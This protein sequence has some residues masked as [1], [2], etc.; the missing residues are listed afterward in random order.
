MKRIT[1]LA[2]AVALLATS[3]QKTDI[4]NVAEDAIDFG[5][6]VGKLTKASENNPKATLEAQDFRVWTVADFTVGTDT[7]YKIYRGMENLTVEHNETTNG[8]AIKGSTKYLWPAQGN[9]LYFYAISAD[10]TDW[11]DDISFKTN[12][13]PAK[14][15]D[16]IRTTHATGL[17]LEEFTVKSTAH[18]DVMVADVVKK[19]KVSGQDNTVKPNF[20][21]T[22]TKVEFNFKHGAQA[23]GDAA[24]SEAATVILKGIE[25]GGYTYKDQTVAPGLVNKG[26]LAVTYDFTVGDASAED[27]KYPFKWSPSTETSDVIPFNKTPETVILIA[28]PAGTKLEA[29][30]VESTDKVV[31]PTND[32]LCMVYTKSE[33]VDS[34]TVYKY[35]AGETSAWT[36]VEKLNYNSDKKI[37]ASENYEAFAGLVLTSTEENFVTWYMIPQGISGKKV[38]LNYVADGKHLSQEFALTGTS[39]DANN[40]TIQI[41]WDEEKCVKYNVTIAP[42]KIEFSPTVGTWTPNADQNLYN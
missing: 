7:K 33:G 40:N 41:V 13:L 18:D 31:N 15:E 17:S 24:A 9:E 12:F 20:R 36:E 26:T 10:D 42:H 8:W 25:I 14:E 22:M 29:A 37:W 21:H 5:V 2:A 19:G 32:Q 30:V 16:A 28:K 23:T 38:R 35:V 27:D 6:Q 39:K 4:L 3:C 34:Y 11:L 1:Y